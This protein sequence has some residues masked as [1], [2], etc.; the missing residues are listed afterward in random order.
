LPAK[1]RRAQLL[2]AADKIFSQKGYDGASMESIARKAGVTK[3]ALYFHFKNKEEVFLAVIR[4]ITSKHSN[5]LSKQL[6]EAHDAEIMLE[7]VI[8]YSYNMMEKRRNFTIE[9]WQQSFKIPRVHDY[10]EKSYNHMASELAAFMESHS[11]LTHRE[12]R[13]LIDLVHALMHGMLVQTICHKGNL[14]HKELTNQMINMCKLYL[15]KK[16]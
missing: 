9:F 2:K 3:G 1:K 8:H 7:K 14:N 5:Y 11:R 10:F 16:Q 4:E 15:K 6:A 12:A 13:T